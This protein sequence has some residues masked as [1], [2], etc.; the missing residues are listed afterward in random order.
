[1]REWLSYLC[2]AGWAPWNLIFIWGWGVN[3]RH[4]TYVS[5]ITT[6]CISLIND[7]II[8]AIS[9]TWNCFKL[10]TKCVFTQCRLFL[11]RWHLPLCV[12]DLIGKLGVK[13]CTKTIS[14]RLGDEPFS[15]K[16]AHAFFLRGEQAGG[17]SGGWKFSICIVASSCWL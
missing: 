8:Q 13:K 16:L 9:T 15:I 14:W 17:L 3:G 10:E 7:P 2:L 6:F 1:M 4:M 12:G 11:F 5:S